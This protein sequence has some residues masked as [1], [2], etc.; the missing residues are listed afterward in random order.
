MSIITKSIFPVMLRIPEPRSG[1]AHQYNNIGIAVAFRKEFRIFRR[2]HAFY[3]E[4]TDSA[5]KTRL[6]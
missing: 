5:Q 6:I 2:K 1:F 3:M 4:R